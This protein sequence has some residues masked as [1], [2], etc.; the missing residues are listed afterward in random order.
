M[1][2]ETTEV[3]NVFETRPAVVMCPPGRTV[4]HL[5]EGMAIV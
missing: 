3:V 5:R 2:D 4:R 1:G